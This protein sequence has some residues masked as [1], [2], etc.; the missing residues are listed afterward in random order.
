[1]SDLLRLYGIVE[2]SIVAGVTQFAPDE[3]VK[4]STVTES[5]HKVRIFSY[6]QLVL[7]S[8]GIKDGYD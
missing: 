2:F 7:N 1:M 6:H 3:I 8:V 4:E 5:L